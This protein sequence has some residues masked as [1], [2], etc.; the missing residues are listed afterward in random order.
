M[1]TCGEENRKVTTVKYLYSKFQQ[2]DLHTSTSTGTSIWKTLYHAYIAYMQSRG[3]GEKGGTLVLGTLKKTISRHY[4]PPPPC[5]G[6][7][8]VNESLSIPVYDLENIFRGWRGG[9]PGEASLK[10]PN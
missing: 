9:G 10:F 2:H 5:L 1:L 3:H 6:R 8:G 7:G 4:P